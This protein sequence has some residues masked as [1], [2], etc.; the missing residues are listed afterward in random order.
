ME[1]DPGRNP[2]L[3]FGL[4]CT[5]MYTHPHSHVHTRTHRSPIILKLIFFSLH[6]NQFITAEFNF[7]A[8]LLNVLKL[9]VKNFGIISEFRP[10][11]DTV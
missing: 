10:P 11:G 5:Y 9:E 4:H 1:S 2:K 3:T 6:L 7:S 8:K